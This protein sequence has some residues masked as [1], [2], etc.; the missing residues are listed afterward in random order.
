MLLPEFLE[1]LC[2]TVDN[3]SPITSGKPKEDCP[4]EKRKAQPLVKEL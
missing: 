4:L 3:A 1:A 2:R